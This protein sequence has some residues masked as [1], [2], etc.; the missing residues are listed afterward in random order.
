MKYKIIILFSIILLVIIIY[1][2]KINEIK[3]STL[4]VYK[5]LLLENIHF[6]LYPF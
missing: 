2:Y 3:K 4:I 6:N 5:P 1:S